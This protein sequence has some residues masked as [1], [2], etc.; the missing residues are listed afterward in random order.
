VVGSD[1]D[2]KKMAFFNELVRQVIEPILTVKGFDLAAV[3]ANVLDYVSP[4]LN[5][6][7]AYDE[8]DDSNSVFVWRIWPESLM[9]G[10]DIIQNLFGG[11]ERINDVTT[12]QFI[13]NLRTFFLNE[14]S[15][16]ISGDAATITRVEA[17]SRQQN[18]EYTRK[19]SRKQ[20]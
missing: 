10:D 3:R 7:F 17:Y 13:E 1:L 5:I 4:H 9:L 8:M 18:L 15:A 14:G 2:Q 20:Q 6:R 19:V 16:L 12:E 11:S